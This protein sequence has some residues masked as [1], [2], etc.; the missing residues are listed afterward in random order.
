V[1]SRTV[2][3]ILLALLAVA[4][5]ALAARRWLAPETVTVRA[6]AVERGVVERTATNTRAGTVEARQRAKLSPDQ[7]GRVAAVP[8]RKG[9]MVHAGDVVLRLDDSLE[10]G[11]V[12]LAR[13]QLAA[14]SAERERVCVAAERAR[15]EL[16]RNRRLAEQEIL[17][18]DLLDRYESAAREADAACAVA[19]AGEASGRAS[20]A[21][22]ETALDKRTLTAPFDGVVADLSTEVGEWVTPSPPAVPVPAVIDLIDPRSIYLSLPMDE[23]DSAR[24]ARGLVARATVDSHPGRTFPARVA[25]V[26]PYVLDLEAQ[27]RTVE[28]EVELDDAALAASLLPGTSADI[29]VV[30]ERR[31]SVLRLPT[32]AILAGDRVLAIAGDRLVEK[33][34]RRGLANWDFT[35]IESGLAEGERVVAAIDRPEIVAGA[36]VAVEPSAAPRP[37]AP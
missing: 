21:L 14:A 12:D 23:V 1:T 22:A 28:I 34:I 8:H 15:R 5:L 17:A 6:V 25:R 7:G 32:A 33:T 13:R 4:L 24:L 31:E 36:R 35:E 20:L 26:A 19:A 9:D 30:L 18:A 29:E 11:Q 3:R 2:R 10:R 16:E 37:G 27:N